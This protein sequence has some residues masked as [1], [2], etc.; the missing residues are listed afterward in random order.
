MVPTDEL[1]WPLPA[2]VPPVPIV[3]AEPEPLA[4]P[5]AE[6]AVPTDELLW[7][8]PAEVPPVPSVEAEP[9]PEPLPAA[10]PA[11]PTDELDCPPPAE[12]PPVPIVDAE[13]KPGAPAEDPPVPTDELDVPSPADVPPVPIVE[14]D[15]ARTNAALPARNVAVNA[16]SETERSF[17]AGLPEHLFSSILRT[18]AWSR[19]CDDT[20][21]TSQQMRR[22]A[23]PVFSR[24][25]F[26]ERFCAAHLCESLVGDISQEPEPTEDCS[27]AVD[28]GGHQRPLPRLATEAANLRTVAR[29]RRTRLA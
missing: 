14:L 23:R 1:L 11:V 19:Q 16:A 6:P 2:E 21:P 27:S 8:L 17:I 15:C 7:P 5:A 18:Q 25:V 29:A 26:R 22:S 4:L 20:G 24:S 13:P 10:E 28:F 12:V 3:D 9:E